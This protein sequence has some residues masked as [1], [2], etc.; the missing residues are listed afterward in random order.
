MVDKAALDLAR[1]ELPK[2]IIPVRVPFSPLADCLSLREEPRLCISTEFQIQE[3]VWKFC[4]PRRTGDRGSNAGGADPEFTETFAAV[5][6]RDT[7]VT[8]TVSHIF[9][10]PEKSAY[11]ITAL[12]LAIVRLSGTGTMR[13]R[14]TIMGAPVGATLATLFEA[15]A[16]TQNTFSLEFP[17]GMPLPET[18]AIL[19]SYTYVAGV[20]DDFTIASTLVREIRPR[21]TWSR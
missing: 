3:S 7:A 14:V 20:G 4:P 10:P 18:E 11:I 17:G 6:R 2:Q 1:A 19:F 12:L 21:G 5:S 13:P 9:R 8:A 15:G 16:Q